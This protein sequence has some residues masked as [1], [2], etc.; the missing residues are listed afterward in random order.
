MLHSNLGLACY[1]ANRVEDAMREWGIVT[2]INKQY[3]M[4]RAKKQ[5]SEYDD[6][7]IVYVPLFTAERAIYTSPKVPDFIMN[8]VPSYS[9]SR[10]DLIID[11]PELVRLSELRVNLARVDRKIRATQI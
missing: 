5:Q 4:M 3:A 1:F 11:N 7:S 2:R 6:A 9:A 8:F 10:L